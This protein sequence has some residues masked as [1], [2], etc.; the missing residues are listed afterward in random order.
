MNS[1]KE[2]WQV[3]IYRFSKETGWNY[4]QPSSSSSSK[5]TTSSTNHPH[6]RGNY[7]DTTAISNPSSTDHVPPPRI[8]TATPRSTCIEISH[9][10]VK[11]PIVKE[12][13]ESETSS[14]TVFHRR[15]DKL[16][17]RLE[18]GSIVLKFLNARECATFC[19]VL[20]S[21]N[22]DVFTMENNDTVEK[23]SWRKQT[24]RRKLAHKEDT[25]Q[26]N[27]KNDVKEEQSYHQELKSYMIH[28]IHDDDFMAFVNR[29]ES[30]LASDPSC[31]KMM[32]A[33]AVT[34]Y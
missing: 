12:S 17:I 15:F 22:K 31:T 19:D 21:L 2:H 33:L 18:R 10:R 24:K 32:Q 16:L 29:V 7:K 34:K 25:Q 5:V 1:K 11:I 20:I 27:H 4:F 8:I 30:V 28:L 23:D 9:L 3:S 14:C 26:R 13:S 6:R